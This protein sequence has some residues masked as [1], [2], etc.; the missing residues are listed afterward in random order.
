MN[1]KGDILTGRF[2]QCSARLGKM[3]CGRAVIVCDVIASAIDPRKCFYCEFR[4]NIEI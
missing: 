2:P 1:N 4:Q 3:L